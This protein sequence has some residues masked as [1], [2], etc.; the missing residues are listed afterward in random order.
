MALGDGIRRNVA[1]VSEEER[2]RL[3]AAFVALDSIKVYPDGVSYW[4]KQEQ[5]HK[6]A[7]AGGQNVHSGPAFLSW[8]REL[9]NRLEALLREVDSELSLHY[10]DWTTDPRASD[11]GAGGTTNLFS[12]TFMGSSSGD[13]GPPLELRVQRGRGARHRPHEDLARPQR[14][15]A[16][17]LER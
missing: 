6:D 15:G 2:D 9:C 12:A 16:G 5:I 14:R 4:D 1:K 13:A 3:L 10:W 7:H 11:D 17:D 8:H